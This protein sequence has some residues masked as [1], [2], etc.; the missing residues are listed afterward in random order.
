MSSS[1]KEDQVLGLYNEGDEGADPEEK[2]VHA[3]KAI[4]NLGRYPRKGRQDSVSISLSL[5]SHQYRD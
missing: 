1:T 3:R 4:E 2:E 5:L